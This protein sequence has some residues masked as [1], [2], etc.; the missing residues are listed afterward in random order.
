MLRSH[1]HSSIQNLADV[2]QVNEEWQAAEF[3]HLLGP[4]V[5]ASPFK[6]KAQ[7]SELTT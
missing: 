2:G 5:V 6:T 4:F 3:S 1:L 7:T